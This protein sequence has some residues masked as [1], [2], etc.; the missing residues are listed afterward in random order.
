MTVSTPT[1][2]CFP[3]FIVNRNESNAMDILYYKRFEGEKGVHLLMSNEAR[4]RSK[5]SNVQILAIFA[6]ILSLIA[7]AIGVYIA[8]Q[9]L[10]THSDILVIR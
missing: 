4:Q 3:Q 9:S 5:N 2:S 10:M 6:A 1:P 7:A 8:V